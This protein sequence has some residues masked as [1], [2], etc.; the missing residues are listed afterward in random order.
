MSENENNSIEFFIP[1]D[2]NMKHPEFHEENLL[3]R[4]PLIDF[5]YHQI[6]LVQTD[7]HF[8]YSFHLEFQSDNPHLSYLLIYQ[9]NSFANLTNT[10]GHAYFCSE[11][12]HRLFINHLSTIDHQFIVIGIRELDSNELCPA[13][14][15]S[16]PMDIQP[17]RFSSNYKFRYYSSACFYRDDNKHWRTDGL[18]VGS[19]TNLTHTHCF[20]H[21]L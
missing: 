8:N 17:R 20:S 13:N 18:V 10:D 3:K 15:S 21:R 16:I 2:V 1:R 19:Q 5:N 4:N 11:N 7:S 9:F 12:L 6:Q 14:N